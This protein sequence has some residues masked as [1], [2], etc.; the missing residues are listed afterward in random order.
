M[1]AFNEACSMGGWM[2]A[3]WM[4]RGKS[5]FKDCLQQSKIIRY[6]TSKLRL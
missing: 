6:L 1:I 5:H 3:G 2:G 4:E